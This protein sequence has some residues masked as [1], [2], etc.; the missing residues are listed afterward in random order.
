MYID[1]L[2]NYMGMLM[3]YFYTIVKYC[4]TKKIKYI[5][6]PWQVLWNIFAIEQ[7]AL[8]NN[9]IRSAIFL[10]H[11]LI[12]CNLLQYYQENIFQII[13]LS[14]NYQYVKY[15]LVIIDNINCNKDNC[16]NYNCV[17]I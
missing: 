16:N 3:N 10:M 9:E 15:L 6:L 17:K 1:S 4:I 12:S 8:N 2:I 14:K 13:Y 7:N 5:Q 11:P